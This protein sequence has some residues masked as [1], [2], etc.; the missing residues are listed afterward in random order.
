[1]TLF[2]SNLLDDARALLAGFVRQDL[3]RLS[4]RLRS[5]VE[6]FLLRRAAAPVG[7]PIV[8]PHVGTIAEVKA[9]GS[10]VQAGQVV[11]TLELLGELIDVPASVGGIVDSVQSSAG[12]LVQY[13]EPIAW[14]EATEPN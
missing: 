14:I 13:G 8:A 9:V 10:L 1:M 11:A 12:E 2:D 4:V 6:L 3:G 7:T 5:D